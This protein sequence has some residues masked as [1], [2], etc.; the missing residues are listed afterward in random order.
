MLYTYTAVITR[1]TDKCYARIPD[2][3][4]CVTTGKNVEDAVVQIT[5]ALR[6]CLIALEAGRVPIAPATSQ[7][8]IM[9][10]VSD[11]LVS[12]SVDTLT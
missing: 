11:I 2:I 10:S 9:H 12:I 5:D 3:P 4:G 6:G 7:Q 1:G 8:E